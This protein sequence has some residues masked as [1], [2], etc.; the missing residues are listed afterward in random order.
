MKK[1]NGLVCSGCGSELDLVV[2]Y[3]G[4][5]VCSGCGSELD[6]VVSYDGLDNKAV[7][8]DKRFSPNW[9]YEI[10]LVCSK[11]GRAY[12]ICRTDKDSHISEITHE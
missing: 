3:D 8:Y 5:L 6:L 4:L 7:D 1:F 2:S 10:E 9:G 12:G 11:C